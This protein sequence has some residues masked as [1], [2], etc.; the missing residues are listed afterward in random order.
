[1][2][3]PLLFPGFLQGARKAL[4]L[5]AISAKQLRPRVLLLDFFSVLVS[6]GFVA[7]PAALL[8]FVLLWLAQ[9]KDTLLLV[10]ER[11][12][13]GNFFALIGLLLSQILWS[14]FSELGVRY[15]LAI[16]DN[17]GINLSRERVQW[18]QTLQKLFAAL[19]L[20]WP[21]VLILVSLI[22]ILFSA[23]YL[24]KDIRMIYGSIAVML[25]LLVQLVL[26]EMY[27]HKYGKG[28]AGN[29]R[30]TRLGRRALPSLEQLW[31]E[32]LY[33][34]YND[35]VYT[36]PKATNFKQSYRSGLQQFNDLYLSETVPNPEFPQNQDAHVKARVVPSSFKLL[37]RGNNKSSTA[38]YTWIYQIPIGF[39]GALHRQVQR[40][41]LLSLFIIITVALLPPDSVFYT[42]IGAPALFCM[43][44]AC[45]TGLYCGFLYLDRALTRNFPIS[46]RFLLVG[47]ILFI[48]FVN[49]DHP[50]HM[51]EGTAKRNTAEMQ[52]NKWFKAYIA[53]FEGKRTSGQKY[54][55]IFICA[56]GGAFRTGAYTALLLTQIETKLS[57]QMDFRRSVFAMSGV[58]G[59]AVGL[60]F[61]NAVAY[62]SRTPLKGDLL[63]K[64]TKDFFLHDSLSPILGRMFYGEFLNLFYWN[65]LPWLDR[66]VALEKTWE[67][68]YEKYTRQPKDNTFRT[69]FILPDTGAI[70]PLLMI[71]TTEVESG[72]QCIMS[73]TSLPNIAFAD[74]RDL[75]KHMITNTRYSAAINLSTRFPLFSPAAMIQGCNR[76]FHYLDG[77][78]VDNTGASSMLELIKLIKKTPE[79]SQVIPVVISLQFGTDSLHNNGVHFLNEFA[80]IVTALT[81]TRQGNSEMALSELKAEIESSRGIWIEEP[82]NAKEKTIPMNWVLSNKSMDTLTKNINDKLQVDGTLIRKL[83]RRDVVYLT[84]K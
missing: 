57:K 69:P 18:R 76:R 66:A 41:S 81:N 51:S 63:V 65:N 25:I 71:N 79:Y 80:E 1:M 32:K 5:I 2:I 62:R 56:E 10:I 46:F 59:G 20:V 61:Y 70:K 74:D 67:N 6:V 83:L 15:A 52:F 26:T 11:M 31:L 12:I 4:K 45:Y 68:A 24:P 19:F 39:Y 36:L 64:R 9:G 29:P 78:Y 30:K 53:R 47:W 43:A 3:K 33:G 21:G 72:K 55:V 38:V 7:V 17:S 28:V 37:N 35:Y 77:G 54:P 84:I 23:D 82:L 50:L 42:Q 16:S 22:S 27:F 73:T 14:I 8:G 58:S 40:M 49:N 48:S 60:G 13:S 75:L 34:I 44:L